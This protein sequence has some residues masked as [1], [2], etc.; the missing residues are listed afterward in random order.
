MKLNPNKQDAIILKYSFDQQVCYV[1]DLAILAKVQ[2]D[3]S[4]YRVGRKKLYPTF[5]KERA[6]S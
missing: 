4:N 1:Y 5:P 3:V 6:W 2:S